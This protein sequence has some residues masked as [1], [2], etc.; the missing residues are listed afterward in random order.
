MFGEV[1][2]FDEGAIAVW[3]GEGFDAVVGP[4]KDRTRKGGSEGSE[5]GSSV[6][7]RGRR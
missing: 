4:L 5:F 6:R 1:A 7:E 2:S 3:A